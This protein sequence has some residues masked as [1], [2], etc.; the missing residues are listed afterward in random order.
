MLRKAADELD[1]ITPGT[2]EAEQDDARKRLLEKRKDLEFLTPCVGNM[3]VP[4]G[5][6]ILNEIAVHGKG[7]DPKTK[8]LLRRQA[9]WALAN[10]GE[11]VKRFAS[12]SSERRDKILGDLQTESLRIGA[13]SDSAR[14]ALQ[15]LQ[16]NQNGTGVITALAEC[17]KADD[18][19]LR[20]LVA[21]ALTFWEGDGDEKALAEKTLHALAYD[22][23]RGTRIEIGDAD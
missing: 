11:N 9:V 19:F 23:G 1:R 15:F 16:G 21:L 8:A 7:R 4:A 22:D 3:I 17:S 2:T 12:L 13:Q 5:I 18:P 10:L 6:P 20:T 14:V